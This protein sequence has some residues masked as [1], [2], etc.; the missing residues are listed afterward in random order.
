MEERVISLETDKLAKEK[1]INL[2]QCRCGGFPECICVDKR[3][4]QSLLQKLLREKYNI[5]IW[6]VPMYLNY[7]NFKY[8]YHI[9]DFQRHIISD[10]G[11]KTYDQALE[12]ALI[13]SLK[14]I[15]RLNN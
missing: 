1:G 15:D 5:H 4:T 6:I 12:E 7:P 2:E 3:S 9:E 8:D 10:K 13:E 14:Y 11:C